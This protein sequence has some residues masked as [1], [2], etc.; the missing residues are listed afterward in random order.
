MTP[1][2]ELKKLMDELKGKYKA[3]KNQLDLLFKLNNHFF[4]QYPEKG[5]A[6]ITC[7]ARVYNRLKDL[8]NRINET[9]G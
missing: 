4:P 6:C 5:K 3:D 8:N 9:K 1:E 2:E 7:R